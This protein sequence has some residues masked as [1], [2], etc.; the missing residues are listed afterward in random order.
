MSSKSASSRLCFVA[1]LAGAALGC[2]LPVLA[3]A[4]G[5]K[6]EYQMTQGIALRAMYDT[7]DPM[8]TAQ[9]AVYAPSDPS[10][11]WLTG[12]ADPKGYFSFVP[13]P[14]I[15]GQW[16]IQAREAGHGALIHVSIGEQGSSAAADGASATG[17]PQA[18]ATQATISTGQS[19]LQRW[20]MIAS[21]IWGF[22][23]TGLF[24]A[25]KR[26]S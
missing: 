17:S 22:I 10:K 2:L 15:A 12:K 18:A 6:I 7:G 14:S 1:K 8:T 16:T 11:P 9:I 21:V 3:H 24:F 25:R 4:H 26:T 23:G 20:L 5:A 19:P 13:D